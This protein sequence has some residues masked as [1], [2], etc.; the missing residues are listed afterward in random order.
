[1]GNFN[2]LSQDGGRAEFSKNLRAS[3]FNKTYR[4]TPLSARSI[5]L[6]CIPLGK[7]AIKCSTLLKTKIRMVTFQMISPKV[8]GTAYVLYQ[9]FK[10]DGRGKLVWE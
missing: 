3:P 4:M 2:W 6:V 5:S 1:M 10:L 8:F 9:L 7:V